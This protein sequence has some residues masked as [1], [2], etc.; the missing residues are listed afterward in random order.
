VTPPVRT[1]SVVDRV[2]GALVARVENGEFS[3]GERLPPE[4]D[5][6]GRR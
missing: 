1:D 3:A 2:I 4:A 5:L 6:R